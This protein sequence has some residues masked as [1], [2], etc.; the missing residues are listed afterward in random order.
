MNSAAALKNS[1]KVLE[2][3]NCTFEAHVNSP[4]FTHAP[5]QL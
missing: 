4:A 5:K 1:D 2:A 3:G